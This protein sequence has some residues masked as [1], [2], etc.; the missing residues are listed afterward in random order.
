M[1]PQSLALLVH[2]PHPQLRSLRKGNTMSDDTTTTD[3]IDPQTQP[4]YCPDCEVVGD[5]PCRTP[6]GR[7]AKSEHPSRKALRNVDG[8]TTTTD[9]PDSP[10]DAPQEAAKPT[11]AP[12]PEPTPEEKKAA[13]DAAIATAKDRL[14]THKPVP[15]SVVRVLVGALDQG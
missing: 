14:D 6:S 1:F 15:N 10:A 9:A 7:R 8:D 4:G 12:K 3:V 11:P 13:L 2:H 5:D